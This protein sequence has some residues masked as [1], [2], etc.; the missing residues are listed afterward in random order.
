MADYLDRGVLYLG[1]R[2]FSI[3]EEFVM[4]RWL[5]TNFVI[6][7]GMLPVALLLTATALLAQQSGTITGGLNGTVVDSTSAVVSGAT[8][9]LTGPQGTREVKTDAQG[10]YG[11]SGLVPGFYDATVEKAGFKKVKSVH[12]EVVVNLSSLLNFTLPV[13][14]AEETVE[15]TAT[16]VGIDTEST[17]IDTNLTDTF[18]NS[19]P[20]PPQVSAIFYAAPGAAAGQVA[21]T[22]NQ[23]GPGARTLDWRFHRARKSV[24]CGWRDHH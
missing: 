5:R 18:Y 8:I 20:M 16:A 1:F 3:L 24:C 14:N 4:V 11:I 23:A 22:P 12:N 21:G 9:T 15:V 13:G 10:H 6:A 7:R 17:A 19:I 2:F